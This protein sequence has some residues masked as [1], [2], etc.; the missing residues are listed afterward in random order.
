MSLTQDKMDAILQ[1]AF[2]NILSSMQMFEF[3]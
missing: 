2:F 3:R 1:M